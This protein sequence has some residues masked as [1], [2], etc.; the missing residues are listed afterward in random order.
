MLSAGLRPT[1]ATDT[2]VNRS[3]PALQ[4]TD[5]Y[6]SLFGDDAAIV[7]VRGS[8]RSLLLTEDLERLLGLE[9]CLSGN[10]PPGVVPRGGAEGPC[11]QIARQH[12]TR[13]VFGPGTFINES[14]AQLQNQLQAQTGVEQAQQ[15][16]AELD[17]YRIAL[18]EHRS[19]AEAL[20]LARQA[21][22]VV[23]ATFTRQ[24][25]VLALHYGLRSAPALN[26]PDFVSALVFDPLKPLGTP[27]ARFSALFP[28]PDAAIV[29]VRL[30]PN[31]S[32]AKR[33]RAI[34]LIRAAVAMPDWQP[35]HGESYLVTGVPV[36][37]SDLV[38]RISG[39]LALL[40]VGALVV[41]AATLALVFGGRPRMLPL[42]V[43][44]AATGLTF[45]A[46]RLSGAELT[47]AS[48]GVLPVLIG[49]GVDYAI[50]LQ[51]RQR[52]ELAGGSPEYALRRAAALG[53]P[54]VLCA[55]LAT[56]AGFMVLALP[57][58][59]SP[60]PMVRDFGALLVVGVLLALGCALTAGS[61]ALLLAGR[62][63]G[64]SRRAVD[65]FGRRAWLRL[66]PSLR[67]AGEI[68]A[69]DRIGA[70]V[71]R[72]AAWAGR[73]AF[74][75]A[76]RRPERVLT[77]AVVLAA[78]G[79]ALDTQTSVES[80][81]QKLV[82][83][84]LQSL[85][86]LNTLQRSTHVGGEIDV[87]ISAPDLTD[88]AVIEWMTSYERLVLGRFGYTP[89]RGCGQAELC[90]AFSLPDLFATQSTTPTRADITSLLDAV[91]PYLSE[92]VI[93]PDRRVATLAFGIRL[94]P[95]ARQEQVIQAMRG[96]LHPPA[97]VSAQLVGLPVLA[98]DANAGI[99]S[100]WRRIGTLLASLVA[101]ALV[102]LLV[103]G[104][105]RRALVPLVPIALA[106]GWS[107]LLL[108][109]MRV[110]LN[111]MSVTLG[112]L[113]IAISTEFSVLLAER[114]RQERT[115]GLEAHAA[116]VRTYRS[117]GAAVLASG[118]TAVAGF[119]VLAIS[120]VRMLRDF[121]LVTVVDLAVS[122]L[123]VMVVLPS[124]LL[125]A[126]RGWAWKL[127]RHGA[128]APARDATPA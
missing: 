5:R 3:S 25:L 61:A 73:D 83:Q 9:G 18:A 55:G 93:T 107:A 50:Q 80:D 82:P 124:V 22:T 94:M 36:I 74:S 106:S 98:A 48:I 45:G 110:P 87:M 125:L 78:V 52:E 8:L 32:D 100:P 24:L 62:P 34:A 88:P 71:R 69:L 16:S 23:S 86:N 28:T 38:G 123:G 42:G 109:A 57:G 20:R 46:L 118:A 59:G 66:E 81:V 65:E 99:S 19:R 75:L 11:A 112:A 51:S 101:V 40:L 102:L 56:A 122:L 90:P 104:A 92:G 47:M 121:G 105:A 96:A 35:Q 91:P 126:E 120:D 89:N 27:K 41:M 6:H 111:P 37:V 2:L 53:A 127:T 128:G 4:A 44:L 70:L 95:L 54:T 58:I 43:A 7:L 85:R 1:A 31:L 30:R 68:L 119:G 79:W 33:A 116:L 21:A 15:R 67:G 117:T 72:R 14:V 108:F 84:D 113:V 114:Y 49:L 13:Y 97:G 103:L 39:A 60:V 29:Q 17:A 77:V 63:R 64:A 10:V 12:A 26:D 76:L 115:G